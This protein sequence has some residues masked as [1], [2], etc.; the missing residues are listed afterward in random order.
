[1][2]ERDSLTGDRSDSDWIVRD[3]IP[4][5]DAAA[6]LGIYAPFVHDSSKWR[7]AA[8]PYRSRASVRFDTGPSG[9]YCRWT[10][11]DHIFF[12]YRNP[13]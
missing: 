3:A 2:A 10:A 7:S 1:M 4:D 6:C 8:T 5:A 13:A 12:F 9:R 11:M